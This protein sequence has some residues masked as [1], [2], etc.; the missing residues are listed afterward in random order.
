[1]RRLLAYVGLSI[2]LVMSG[3]HIHPRERDPADKRKRIHNVRDRLA[4]RCRES[5]VRLQID[6]Q[7]THAQARNA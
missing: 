2:S 4:C 1:M 7:N 3:Y 5:V 6:L